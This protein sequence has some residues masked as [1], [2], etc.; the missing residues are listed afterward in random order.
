MTLHIISRRR[1]DYSKRREAISHR[2]FRISLK[3]TPGLIRSAVKWL[4]SPWRNRETM[5]FPAL[6]KWHVRTIG[7]CIMWSF[8]II[9]GTLQNFNSEIKQLLKIL[10]KQRLYIFSKVYL[11]NAFWCRAFNKRIFNERS[12]SKKLNVF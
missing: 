8:L 2:S 5:Q 1:A 6:R 4:Q 12:C 11:N 7:F 10:S 9:F 3:H